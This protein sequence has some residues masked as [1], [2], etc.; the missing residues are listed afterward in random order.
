MSVLIQAMTSDDDNEILS[1]LERVKNVSVFGLINESVDVRVGVDRRSAQGMTRPWFAWANS[2]LA[3]CVL[4]LAQE[5]PHLVFEGGAVAEKY[6][7][8]KGFV[9]A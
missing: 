1:C 6:V 3:Q 7:V 4:W 9:G 2:V 8:G 5:R